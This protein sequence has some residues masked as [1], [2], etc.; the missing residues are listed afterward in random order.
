MADSVTYEEFQKEENKKSNKYHDS[1]CDTE[2]TSIEELENTISDIQKTIETLTI[3]AKEDRI[4][5]KWETQQ[6][7]ESLR[8]YQKLMD[9]QMTKYALRIQDLET[10]LSTINEPHSD[11]ESSIWEINTASSDSNVEGQ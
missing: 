2:V 11:A 6:V 8:K 1:P 4:N 9:D 5:Q 10:K 7:K 3:K